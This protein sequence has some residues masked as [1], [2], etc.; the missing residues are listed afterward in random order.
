MA[1]SLEGNKILAALLTAGV[2]AMT[3]GFIAHTIYSPKELA[4]NA[5]PIEVETAAATTAGEDAAEPEVSILEL[6]AAADV[7]KGEKQ[8]KKCAS[9]HSFDEGGPDKVGPNLYD[10]IGNGIANNS[11]FGYSSALSGLSGESWSYE[12]L[13]GFIANPKSWAPGTKMG[14]AGIKRPEQRAD[15][16]AYLRSLSGSPAPLP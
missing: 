13:D 8:A 12:S 14:F 2:I 7:G 6:L 15:L 9:C 11:G 10:L 5:Y 4:E 3:A 16:V 1:G